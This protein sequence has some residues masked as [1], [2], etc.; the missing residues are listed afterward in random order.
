MFQTHQ[1]ETSERKPDVVIIPWKTART[2]RNNG[3]IYEKND[4]Y[5]HCETACAKP[6][7]NFK[8]PETVS[9]VEFKRTRSTLDAPPS[10]YEVRGY[11][12]P[13]PHQ[14]MEYRKE[15]PKPEETTGSR[16]VP[17]PA[18]KPSNERKPLGVSPSMFLANMHDA[19]KRES[20]RLK[21]QGKRP[22]DSTPPNQPE[23]KRARSNKEKPDVDDEKEKAI[24]P[25]VQNGLYAAEMFAPHIARRHVISFLVNG[26][27]MNSHE[28]LSSNS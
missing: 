11:N 13:T 24:D 1:G 26:K 3:D 6:D 7:S 8:W 20:A 15:T 22:S 5:L 14:Y 2:A 25:I 10:S 21:L 27:S 12:V 19:A 23:S 4:M 17:A 18:P 16:P 9:T 28:D